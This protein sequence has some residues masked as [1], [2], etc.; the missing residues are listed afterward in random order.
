MKTLNDNAREYID[1]AWMSRWE[2]IDDIKAFYDQGAYELVALRLVGAGAID[3][4]NFTTPEE[5]KTARHMHSVAGSIGP[6]TERRLIN[7]AL[8]EYVTQECTDCNA[9]SFFKEED[10]PGICY[11][12]LA[13]LN[14]DTAPLEAWVKI[15]KRRRV[16]PTTAL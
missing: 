14:E 7:E 5:L 11:S 8:E 10:K 4:H 9:V 2:N 1:N 13:E 12:C 16:D 6:R 15:K 3:L